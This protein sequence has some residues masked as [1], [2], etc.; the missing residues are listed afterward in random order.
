MRSKRAL[1]KDLISSVNPDSVILQETKL[2]KVDRRLVKSI[3]SSR[4]VAW[5]SLDASN[6]AGGIILMWKE[7]QIDVVNSFLGAFSITIQCSFQG[8]KEGWITGVYGPCDYQDRKRFLL[9]LYDLQGLCQGIWCVVGDF[10]MVRWS[11][12][13]LN[14]NS[15][16]RSMKR[17]N[18]FIDDSDI[19]EMPML[20]GK[21]TWSRMGE[22]AAASKLDR[23]FVSRQW[24]DFFKEGRVERL[25][26]PTSDHF[27]IQM[28]I[29]AFKWGPTPFRFENLW[30]DIPNFKDSE[31]VVG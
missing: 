25:Q 8:Q 11:E 5:L 21:F 14:G 28:S 19:I 2:A 4:H 18:K 10:N 24:L 31:A 26:R 16:S 17:F 15:S 7:N 23:F 1:V 9:E 20:N 22:R 27:P 30:L 6:S 13:R 29:G 12:E 3:W